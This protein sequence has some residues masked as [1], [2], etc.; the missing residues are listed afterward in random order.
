MN[1]AALEFF[2]TY[3]LA[4]RIDHGGRNCAARIEAGRIRDP[5]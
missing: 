1:R 3:T 4:G 2:I 5:G